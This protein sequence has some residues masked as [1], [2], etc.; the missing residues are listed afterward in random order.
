MAVSD[1]NFAS[2][3]VL[4]V[5]TPFIMLLKDSLIESGKGE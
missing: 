1:V 2:L 4:L 5:C 3:I